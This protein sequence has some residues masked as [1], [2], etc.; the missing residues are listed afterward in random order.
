MNENVNYAPHNIFHPNFP[1]SKSRNTFNVILNIQCIGPFAPEVFMFFFSKCLCGFQDYLRIVKCQCC[2]RIQCH[3]CYVLYKISKNNKSL[4]TTIKN[5]WTNFPNLMH[6]LKLACNENMMKYVKEP[7][8][9]MEKQS[10]NVI[11]NEYY[12]EFI[13]TRIWY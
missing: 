9:T 2:P 4:N 13:R 1:N 10:L 6:K 8:N 11:W 7:I 3:F 5:P 12:F